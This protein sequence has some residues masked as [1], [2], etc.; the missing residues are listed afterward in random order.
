MILRGTLKLAKG[1]S[2]GTWYLEAESGRRYQ[3]LDVNDDDLVDGRHVEIEGA[4]EGH[5]M[6]IGM[7]GPIVRV[8]SC[9]TLS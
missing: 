9:K 5:T 6:G 4:E 8:R 2:G 7:V 3:L 1:L